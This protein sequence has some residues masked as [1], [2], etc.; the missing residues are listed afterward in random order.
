[1]LRFITALC[2][3][4]CL[5]LS[6]TYVFAS[7]LP[8]AIVRDVSPEI[9]SGYEI[10]DYYLP[11]DRT[12]FVLLRAPWN[13]Q[14]LCLYEK[15]SSQWYCR[16]SNELLSS[17]DLFSFTAAENGFSLSSHDIALRFEKQEDGWQVAHVRDQARQME[18]W[19]FSGWED[20]VTFYSNRRMG[21]N[22]ALVDFVA[23]ARSA[24]NFQLFT[25]FFLDADYLARRFDYVPDY[26]MDGFWD[27]TCAALWEEA[28]F[29]VYSGPGMHYLRSAKGKAS[30]GCMDPFTVMGVCG[31]WLMVMYSLSD[32]QNRVGYVHTGGHWKLRRTADFVDEIVFA[33]ADY[34]FTNAQAP[35][36]DDPLNAAKAVYTLPAE[37]PVQL[38]AQ[39]DV[40]SY[41]EIN[42]D[43]TITRGFIATELLHPI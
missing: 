29:P 2:L 4:M 19:L 15:E 9:E 33:P 25:M 31:D 26:A 16:W 17:G 41:V 12:C 5:L 38:L 7:E 22:L 21:G 10:M 20:E 28:S 27:S 13:D 40:W 36:Y 32:T 42:Y 3:A 18:A 35:L 30:I 23:T 37:W 43:E 39:D 1:M 6:P 8:E 14:L 24:E 34:T 11:D